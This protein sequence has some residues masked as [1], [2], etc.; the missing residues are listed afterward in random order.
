MLRYPFTQ[1]AGE[2]I[3]RRKQP[4]WISFW[5]TGF[6]YNQGM[7]GELYDGIQSEMLCN[8]R[9]LLMWPVLW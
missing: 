9:I 2:T 7:C 3:F 5:I 1:K 4:R 6:P 8:K